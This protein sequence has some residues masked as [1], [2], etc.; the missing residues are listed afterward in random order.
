MSLDSFFLLACSLPFVFDSD[1]DA[2]QSP[3]TVAET[4]RPL[5]ETKSRPYQALTRFFGI[6]SW[7]GCEFI[8]VT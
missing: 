1:D 2:A 6:K 7:Y 4:T 8:L 5:M 3:K